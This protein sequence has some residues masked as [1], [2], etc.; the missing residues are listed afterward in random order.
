[1]IPDGI[2]K[3]L[4][5]IVIDKGRMYIDMYH[6]TSNISRTLKGKKFVDHLDVVGAPPV[7]AAPAISSFSV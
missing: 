4:F 6:E 1:M 7:S 2:E 5:N 3:L